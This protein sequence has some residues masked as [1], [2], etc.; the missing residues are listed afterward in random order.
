MGQHITLS[1]KYDI[2]VSLTRDNKTA[3]LYLNCRF[4]IVPNRDPRQHIMFRHKF[5]KNMTT[6]MHANI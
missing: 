3:I 1:I 4:S 6:D 2:V 5:A